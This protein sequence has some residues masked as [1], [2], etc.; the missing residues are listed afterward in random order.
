MTPLQRHL[1][2][3]WNRRSH[4][5]RRLWILAAVMLAGGGRALGRVRRRPASVLGAEPALVGVR[6]RHSSPPHAWRRSTVLAAVS[7][8]SPWP[9]HR[10]WSDS[11]TRPRSPAARRTRS[12][13][14]LAAATRRP[15]AVCADRIRH[16]PL[17]GLRERSGSGRSARSRAAPTLPVWHSAVAAHR[18]DG[19]HRP[20]AGHLRG[21]RAPAARARL[22]DRRRQP[23][24]RGLRGRRGVDVHRADRRAPDSHRPAR[25]GAAQPWSR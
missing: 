12:G 22:V 14:A 19:D 2:A 11:S 20:E 5:D 4:I 24:A 25:A 17:R 1:S 6:D 13:A 21:R 3:G 8:R 15:R 18:G 16:R 23:P 10:S 7:R 9:P